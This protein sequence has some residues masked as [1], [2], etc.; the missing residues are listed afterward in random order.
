M[1]SNRISIQKV[2][3]SAKHSSSSCPANTLCCTSLHCCNKTLF[4]LSLQPLRHPLKLMQVH[5]NSQSKDMAHPHP[6]TW[7]STQKG[8]Q[9]EQ[10]ASWVDKSNIFMLLNFETTAMEVTQAPWGLNPASATPETSESVTTSSGGSHFLLALECFWSISVQHTGMFPIQNIYT[11]NTQVGSQKSKIPPGGMETRKTNKFWK[12]GTRAAEGKPTYQNSRV[13]GI[14]KISKSFSEKLR[15]Y[16]NKANGNVPELWKV[17]G[18]NK[19]GRPK[20]QLANACTS[21]SKLSQSQQK[22]HSRRL[23]G[24][25]GGPTH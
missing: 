25:R 24:P 6:Y 18:E 9:M 13:K 21:K 2:Q 22:Q 19:H 3:F 5:K 8:C 23:M 17:M 10:P 11:T 15:L 1:Y 14:I 20:E 12:L 4:F 7:T 16:M